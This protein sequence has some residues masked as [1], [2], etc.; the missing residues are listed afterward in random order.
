MDSWAGPIPVSSPS[1][2]AKIYELRQLVLRG[3]P[4]LI[5]LY[6]ADDPCAQDAHD[7]HGFHWMMTAGGVRIAAAR[8]CIHGDPRELPYQ[9]GYHHLITV[10]DKILSHLGIPTR[11]P[12]RS[13]A[14]RVDLFQKI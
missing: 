10:I 12:P 14:R 11:A 2:L 6:K 7:A 9:E 1:A 4:G 8:M 13:P 3:D 5:G